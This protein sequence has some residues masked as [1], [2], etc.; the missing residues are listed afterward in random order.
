MITGSQILKSTLD[1]LTQSDV[2]ETWEESQA[3]GNYLREILD[4]ISC[5]EGSEEEEKRI[6]VAL[7]AIADKAAENDD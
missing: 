3:R 7:R 6:R 1:E 2:D 5:I 4:A